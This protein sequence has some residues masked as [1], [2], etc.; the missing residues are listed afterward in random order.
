MLVS[1]K[2]ALSPKSQ[3]VPNLKLAWSV[4][5]CKRG[6]LCHTVSH[7][8]SQFNVISSLLTR[9]AYRELKDPTDFPPEHL[10]FLFSRLGLADGDNSEKAAWYGVSTNPSLAPFLWGEWSFNGEWV[11]CETGRQLSRGH[12]APS[13]STRHQGT[14]RGGHHHHHDHH[15]QEGTK[16]PPATKNHGWPVPAIKN[17]SGGHQSV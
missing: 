14:V 17:L 11:H 3:L 15:H 9:P 5:V 6:T 16:Q 13:T 8:A 12:Q 1:I 7:C 10:L 2:T 4:P